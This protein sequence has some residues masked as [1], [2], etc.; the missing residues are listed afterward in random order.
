MSINKSIQL[1]LCCL[2]IELRE[3]KP[4]VF[5]SRRVTLKT[6]EEKGINNLKKKIINNL[7]DV[8]TMMDWNEENG[9]KVFR[10]SSELFPHYSNKKA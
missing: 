10:L 3:Q 7:N 1:G 5:S 2:N 6:L 4:T 9:I 8:L